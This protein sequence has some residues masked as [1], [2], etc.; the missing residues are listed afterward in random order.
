VLW[1]DV[2]RL[3]RAAVVVT[4]LALTLAA[5]MVIALSVST[6]DAGLAAFYYW[7]YAALAEI[8][9]WGIVG[10]R[11]ICTAARPVP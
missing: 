8:I 10:V 1:R 3:A 5:L 11:R 7:M 6:S 4:A 2:S 9:L